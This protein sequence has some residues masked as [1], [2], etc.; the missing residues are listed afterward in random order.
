MAYLVGTGLLVLVAIGMPLQYGAGHPGVVKVVG[1]IHGALY[2]VYLF[3][4][5]DLYRRQRF[6]LLQLAA[7]IGAGFIPLLAF[8]VERRVSSRLAQPSG[9]PAVV[10]ELPN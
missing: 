1:P 2:I 8:V 6:S 9:G 4:A 3:A 10:S 7:M 5:F